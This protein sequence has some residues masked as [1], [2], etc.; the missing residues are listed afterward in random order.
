MKQ[1]LPGF[2]DFYPDTCAVRNYI[3]RIFR[4]V[5]KAY[6]FEEFDGPILEPLELFVAKSGDEIISQLFSF[7]DK[8]GRDVALRPELTPSL[9]RMV[10]AKAMAL[11]RP[12]R[13][14][15]VGEH[16]RYERPQKGRLRA[17]FQMN[18]DVLGERHVRADAELIAVL[19]SFFCRLGL[20]AKDFVIR[21]SDRQLW[22]K[23]LHRFNLEEG[24]VSSVLGI[25]DKL[26]RKDPDQSKKDLEEICPTQGEEIFAGIHAL[27]QCRTLDEIKNIFNSEESSRLDDW[28]QLLQLLGD[29][30]I[31]PFVQ[32]D[33]SIVR[34]LAYYTG[35]VFEAFEREGQN[36]A[37]AG[38][39]RYDNL[40][41][42]L[43]GVPFP[44]CGFAVGDVTLGNLLQEKNLLPDDDGAPNLFAIF[45]PDT[46]SAALSLCQWLRSNGISLAYAL[47]GE[48]SFFKQLKAAD[49]SG[50]KFALFIGPNEVAAEKFTLK[51]LSTGN[52]QSLSRDELI[53]FLTQKP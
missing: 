30:Q 28:A 42:K 36:R 24:Q 9:A 45:S 21:I 37:L 20:T 46:Q 13:W 18:V 15:N 27:R 44:A 23:F 53:P 35:F 11:K 39:G 50:A 38:G 31:A 49:K 19:V 3:F 10:A 52:M 33:F 25:I 26:D 40:L 1:A 17:F 32:I 51:N 7:T 16:F 4:Q 22:I 34:G 47:S 41:E 48:P 6:A 43:Y 8:G 29:L 14:C 2:R 5:A 12:I